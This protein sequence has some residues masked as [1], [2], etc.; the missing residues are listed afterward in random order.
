MKHEFK[1]GDKVRVVRRGAIEEGWDVEMDRT[2]GEIGV[3]ERITEDGRPLPLRIRFP[4]FADWWYYKTEW[5][6]PVAESAPSLS[7]P[8]PT[9]DYDASSAIAAVMDSVRDLFAPRSSTQSTNNIPLIESTK[10][11]TDIKLD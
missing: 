3:I 8:M 5:V 7:S 4:Q 2:L 9:I 6:E 10:L 11:L 1:V